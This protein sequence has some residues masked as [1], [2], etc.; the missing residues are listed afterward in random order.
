MVNIDVVN[1]LTGMD[2][3]V[4]ILGWA[5]SQIKRIKM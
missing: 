5:A 3:Y 2:P 4:F 1:Q